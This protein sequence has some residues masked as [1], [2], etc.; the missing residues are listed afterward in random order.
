MN[1]KLVSYR[2]ADDLQAALKTRASREGISATE[3]VNR[4]LRQGL[5][6]DVA[7]DGMQQ[8][9]SQ[10]EHL[11]HQLE[12]R[13]VVQAVGDG[14]GAVADCP[15]EPAMA[16]ADGLPTRLLALE[17]KL[18]ALTMGVEEGRHYL[19]QLHR[20]VLGISAL[21]MPQG[22]APSVPKLSIP[23]PSIYPPERSEEVVQLPLATL[24]KLL[25]DQSD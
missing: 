22:S 14:Q 2:L 1:R 15:G 16:A 11:L 9:V 17:Q 12:R 21:E 13:V 5:A 8:R 18:D 25:A 23:A 3:L 7:T 24:R 4:L 10:L 6:M 20:S 19:Q